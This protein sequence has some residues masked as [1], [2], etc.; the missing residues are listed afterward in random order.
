MLDSMNVEQA[1]AENRKYLEEFGG[2][3]A[4]I[5]LMGVDVH[6]GWTHSQVETQRAK[7]GTN[8]F[9]EAPMDSYLKLLFQALTD[10]TLLILIAAATVSTIIGVLSHPDDG[11][12][13]GAAIFIAIFLCSNIA[14][15]NDYTKQLQ[16]RALEN[17]SAEDD[18]CSALRGGNIERINPKELVVG[19][20]L[21]LQAGDMVPADSIIL[22]KVTVK[23]NESSL[24][25]EPDDLKKSPDGDCF[26]L[27]SCLITEGEDCH[28]LVIG[29]GTHSQ[30]GKIKANLVSEAVNTPLQDKLEDMA[31]KVGR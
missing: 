12:I 16:F 3:D 31:T 13:E 29:I 22:S 2:V 6:T 28:A 15:G 20:I 27:S 9:P 23:S 4:L 18:R 14:A 10:G 25:G 1:R 24:T 7:F 5:K 8:A 21:V 11:W 17:S 19:D 30:W 26:L